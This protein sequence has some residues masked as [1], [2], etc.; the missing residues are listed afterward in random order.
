[1]TVLCW[2]QTVGLGPSIR[3]FPEYHIVSG[4]WPSSAV[5]IKATG[6]A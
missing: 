3:A 4:K 1:M 2:V 5:I 6:V